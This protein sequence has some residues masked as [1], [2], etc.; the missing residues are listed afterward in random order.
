MNT[1]AQQKHDTLLFWEDCNPKRIQ[2]WSQ[3]FVPLAP[4]LSPHWTQR[5]A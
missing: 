4:T 5:L 1:T 2:G 3:Y